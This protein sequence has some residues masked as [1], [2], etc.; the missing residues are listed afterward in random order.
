MASC[1][2][3]DPLFNRT[4]G[5]KRSSVS[6]NPVVS[7]ESSPKT[8]MVSITSQVS[9]TV[10][11]LSSMETFE[12]ATVT[13]VVPSGRRRLFWG[14]VEAGNPDPACPACGGI[15]KTDTI[16]FGEDLPEEEV[17]KANLYLAI[18]DALL[19]VGSTV[20]VWPAAEIVMRGAKQS[21]PIV[22]LNKGPTDAD[23]VAT[24]K[25][26]S[27]TGEVLPGLIDQIT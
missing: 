7:V 22:I 10:R 16:L 19:I 6:T 20:S 5:T 13:H 18:S 21:K 26:E 8:L 17:R 12:R 1:G 24:V 23:Q 2:V 14:W 3:R 25:V 4:K 15:V 11:S 27:A 9:T